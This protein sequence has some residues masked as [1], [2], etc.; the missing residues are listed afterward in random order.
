MSAEDSV[1]AMEEFWYYGGW[2]PRADKK[3]GLIRWLS[4]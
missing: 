3:G 4:R 1:V 2:G